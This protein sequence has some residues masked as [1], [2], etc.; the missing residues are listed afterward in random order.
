MHSPISQ[1][2]K[3]L[4]QFSELSANSF[5]QPCIPGFVLPASDWSERPLPVDVACGG[6]GQVDGAEEQVRRRQADH[7]QRRRVRTQLRAPQQRH[8][9]QQ[10]ACNQGGAENVQG[11]A[12]LLPVFR[13][14][15]L[16]RPPNGLGGQI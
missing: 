6:E 5:A 10:V 4:A 1:F 15:R 12:L 9:S 8:H 16:F 11:V 14:M 7:E 3:V 2:R 13:Y